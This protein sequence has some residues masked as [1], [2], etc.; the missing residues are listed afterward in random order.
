MPRVIARLTESGKIIRLSGLFSICMLTLVSVDRVYSNDRVVMALDFAAED[1]MSAYDWFKRSEFKLKKSAG[2]PD[3]IEFYRADGAL[4]VVTKKPTFGIAVRK[5]DAPDAR[6]L[7]LQWGIS[8][9]PDGV[10]YQHGIDNEAIMVYVFFGAERLPSGE[11]FIPASPYFIGFYLCP[12]EADE[13]EVPYKGHHYEKTGRFICVDHPA[14]GEMAVNEVHLDEEFAKSFGLEA[15]PPISAISIEVDT[16]DA[17]NDG[18]AAAFIRRL[19][20]LK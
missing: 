2:K 4:H 5:V 6:R 7:R 15:M 9:Y 10:S 19:D 12:P 1:G 13:V 11:M 16:T 14:E 3:K 8:D 20:F 17:G 18:H